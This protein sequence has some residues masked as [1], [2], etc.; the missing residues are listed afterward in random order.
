[1][2]SIVGAVVER[3]WP[4]IVGAAQIIGRD[5]KKLGEL[6]AVAL[7]QFAGNTAPQELL[8]KRM[9]AT[10]LNRHLGHGQADPICPT[11]MSPASS[12]LAMAWKRFQCAPLPHQPTVSASAQKALIL[13]D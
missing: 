10:D 8:Q 4:R 6:L 9:I 3:R 13:L 2:R 12:P 7:P 5:S 1:L 11:A